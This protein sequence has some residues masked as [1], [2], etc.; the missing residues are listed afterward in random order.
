MTT[1]YS[2]GRPEEVSAVIGGLLET[3]REYFRKH[4]L[5]KICYLAQKNTEYIILLSLN[6]LKRKIIS[7]IFNTFFERHCYFYTETF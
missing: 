6:F 1:T 5:T 2:G 4:F 7:Q 3:S